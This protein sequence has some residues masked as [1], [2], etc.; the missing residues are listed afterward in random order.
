MTIANV[1]EA[2][3]CICVCKFSQE[4]FPKPAPYGDKWTLVVYC[5]YLTRIFQTINEV[6]E[7]IQS[8]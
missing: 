7:N 5:A 2:N 1:M 3:V 8:L 6:R 4:L